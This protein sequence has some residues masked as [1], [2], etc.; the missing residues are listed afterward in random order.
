MRGGKTRRE[1]QINRHF[2]TAS[3]KHVIVEI[4]NRIQLFKN[5]VKERTLETKD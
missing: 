4:A 5:L 1:L 2:F 3:T